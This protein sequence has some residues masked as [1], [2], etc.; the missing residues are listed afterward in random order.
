MQR[1][2]RMEQAVHALLEAGREDAADLLRRAMRAVEVRLEGRTDR[3]A[4]RIW[5]GAPDLPNQV[6]LLRMAARLWREFGHEEK[7]AAVAEL[8]EELWAGR[9]RPRERDERRREPR[10]EE[11]QTDRE[12]AL[13]ERLERLE[14]QLA[15]IHEQLREMREA[16]RRRR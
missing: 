12:P 13:M 3:E 9:D 4:R 16:L 15:E 10:R 1:L 14:V 6:E 7:A 8:A 5:E 2:H 11:R